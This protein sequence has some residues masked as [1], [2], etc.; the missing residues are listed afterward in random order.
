MNDEQFQRWLDQHG[1]EVGRTNNEKTTDGPADPQTGTPTKQTT[2]DSTTITSKDGATITLRRQLG[3]TNNGQAY[4]VVGN[5]PPKTSSSADESVSAPP[6]QP[7]IVTR[8]ADGTITTIP[9]PNYQPPTPQTVPTNT[10]DPNI[11]S[12]NPDGSIK[13]VPNPNYQPPKPTYITAQDGTVYQIE[14]GK[15]PKP[16]IQGAKPGSTVSVNGGKTLL[17]VG[18]DG[19]TKVVWQ[20][21]DVNEAA[22]YDERTGQYHV[23]TKDTSGRVTGVRVIS[24]QSEA[25]GKPGPAMPTLVVGMSEAA[26]RQFSDQL[27]QAVAAGD[28]TPAERDKR[29]G[30]AL[31]LAQHAVNE[32]TVIQRDQESNL[33]ARVNLATTRYSQRMTGMSNALKF[34]ADLNDKLP[35][36]SDLGGKGFAALLGMQALIARES[37]IEDIEIPRADMR[38]AQGQQIGAATSSQLSRLTNPAD[39]AAVHADQQAVRSALNTPAPATVPSQPPELPSPVFRPQPPVT[40]PGA[41]PQSVSAPSPGMTPPA[42]A[43]PP[44]APPAQADIFSPVPG[45]VQSAAGSAVPPS[46]GAPDAA[47][48][49]DPGYGQPMTAPPSTY[50]AGGDTQS[51]AAPADDFA[52]LAQQQQ[53]APAPAPAAP[54]MSNHPAIRAAQIE[55]TP[56]WRLSP[57]DLQWAQENGLMDRAM[58]VPEVAASTT[59]G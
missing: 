38:S 18:Q 12:R 11:V 41:A 42:M 30:E 48:P 25:T 6:T 3:P 22:S 2:I 32:A 47:Q 45:N 33:N 34:V 31:S 17:Y 21:S 29:W 15:D 43:P 5:T 49:G 56:P 57:E 19:T 50:G 24:P 16:I 36:G 54:D 4:E 53:P 44:G 39:P 28:M 55:A 13:T 35:V 58:A 37:G 51:M 46:V 23:V 1:G 59:P 26:L 14:P 8:R 20:S 7:N 40:L 27:N 9:N 10:T 52:I